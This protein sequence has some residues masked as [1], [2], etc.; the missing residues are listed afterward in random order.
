MRRTKNA[1]SLQPQALRRAKGAIR[2]PRC[3]ARGAYIETKSII[4]P[5]RLKMVFASF[6]VFASAAA[7]GKKV[8][9]LR[10]PRLMRFGAAAGAPISAAAASPMWARRSLCNCKPRDPRLIFSPFCLSAVRPR[11]PLDLCTGPPCPLHR[12]HGRKA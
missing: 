1:L 3:L 12:S 11:T 10:R 9:R 8:R 6:A 4:S 5:I 7:V 2:L